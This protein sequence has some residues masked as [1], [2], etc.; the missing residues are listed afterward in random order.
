M[1]SK[2][3]RDWEKLDGAPAGMEAVLRDY[4]EDLL[5]REVARIKYDH[6]GILGALESRGGLIDDMCR[7]AGEF[8]LAGSGD[9]EAALRM[10]KY[11]DDLAS[12][13]ATAVTPLLYFTGKPGLEK[14]ISNLFAARFASRLSVRVGAHVL[15]SE[16]TG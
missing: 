14:A 1:S 11:L 6:P 8:F 4:Y 16:E 10:G 7:E 5:T 2:E 15:A 12:A 13:M 3:I 9:P